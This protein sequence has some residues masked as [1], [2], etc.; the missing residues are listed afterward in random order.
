[1]KTLI[2]LTMT[3]STTVILILHMATLELGLGK[4]LHPN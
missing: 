1:M 3:I 2:V 4:Q